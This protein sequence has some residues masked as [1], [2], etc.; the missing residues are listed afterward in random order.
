MDAETLKQVEA[1]RRTME[2]YKTLADIQQE[3]AEEAEALVKALKGEL[4]KI[5]TDVTYPAQVA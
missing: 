1:L 4:S 5:K 2:Y 3:R